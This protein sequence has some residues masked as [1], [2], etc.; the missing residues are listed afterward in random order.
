[1]VAKGPKSLVI[2]I[3]DLVQYYSRCQILIIF[4]AIYAFYFGT[5]W[6][7]L[8]FGGLFVEYAKGEFYI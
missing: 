2:Y 4:Y 6:F 7:D 8:F 5:S 1:M 3:S